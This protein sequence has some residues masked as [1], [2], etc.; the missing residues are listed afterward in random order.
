MDVSALVAAGAST[1]VNLMVTDGWK[2][3]EG[4]FAALLGRGEKDP[5]QAAGELETSRAA[6]EEARRRG[7][8]RSAADLEAYWRVRLHDVIRADGDAAGLLAQLLAEL[9]GDAGA[10]GG[11]YEISG[12]SF[13]GP[14]QI[15]QGGRGNT[16]TRR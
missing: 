16:Q 7:D 13:R 6:L 10:G 8:T 4:R 11:R 14:V 3:A 1:L 5:G 15:Q 2:A 9:Q 12:N